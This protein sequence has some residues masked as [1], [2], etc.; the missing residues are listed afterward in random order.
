M[1]NERMRIMLNTF[2]RQDISPDELF[3]SLSSYHL[4]PVA[5]GAIASYDKPAKDEYAHFHR[6]YYLVHGSASYVVNN[7]TYKVSRNCAV[8]LPPNHNIHIV[9]DTDNQSLNTLLF[10]AFKIENSEKSEEFNQVMA[11]VLPNYQL[12]DKH[13]ILSYPFSTIY[14]EVTSKNMG[15]FGITISLLHIIFTTV[16]RLAESESQDDITRSFPIKKS[17]PIIVKA[18]NYIYNNVKNNIK[19]SELAK[20]L[21]ISEIYLYKLFKEYLAKSPQQFLNDYRIQAAKDYLVSSYYSIQTISDELGYSSS[22]HFSKAFKNATGLSPN[23]WRAQIK[24]HK[25][26]PQIK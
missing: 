24:I 23:Q 9:S 15:Y 3:L 2:I 1:A 26:D 11:S 18:T 22:N 25:H 20:E 19:I 17:N 14:N 12:H 8:Y 16:F 4:L 6:L 7:V 5:G 13:G 10:I 21:E